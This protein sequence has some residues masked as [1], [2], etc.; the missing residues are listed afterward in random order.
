MI[1]GEGP[2]RV[3]LESLASRCSCAARVSLSGSV[4]N[5]GDWYSSA[6]LF[7]LSSRFEGFPNTLLEAMAHG[8]AVIAADC[9]TGP[10]TLVRDG[11]DG[12]LVTPDQS[13][14]SG[15][16]DGAAHG[17]RCSYV[18]GFAERALDTR[19][20]FSVETIANLWTNIVERQVA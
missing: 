6:D 1:V 18:A 10:R 14:E 5:I 17:G 9:P 16:R 7:V 3:Q 12:L 15:C 19:E 13:S 20:R 2:E 11:V 8:I 4:G